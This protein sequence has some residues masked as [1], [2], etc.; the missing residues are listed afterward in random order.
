MAPFIIQH[1][2][3]RIFAGFK[4]RII[5]KNDICYTFT[6]G[7]D[8]SFASVCQT[9]DIVLSDSTTS[10]VYTLSQSFCV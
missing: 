4:Y 6:K 7:Y 2:R 9:T 1:D 5:R 8:P 10:A 3:V